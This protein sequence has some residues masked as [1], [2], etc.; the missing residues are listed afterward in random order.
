MRWALAGVGDSRVVLRGSGPGSMRREGLA[1]RMELIAA[2]TRDTRVVV[3]AFRV[4][5]QQRRELV[6]VTTVV[7]DPARCDFVGRK[8]CLAARQ[9]SQCAWL[10]A[11]D[12]GDD[13]S[14]D[15]NA[16][17]HNGVERR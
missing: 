6:N 15:K 17:Q 8:A 14:E 10:Q 16:D 9:A 4:I 12:Y 7:E 3:Q 2:D 5:G 1:S 11:D 13:L